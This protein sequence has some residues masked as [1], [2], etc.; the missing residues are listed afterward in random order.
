MKKVNKITKIFLIA[1]I[2]LGVSIPLNTLA[3]NDNIG[4]S[5]KIYAYQQNGKE[6]NGRYRQTK[7][8]DNPWKVKLNSSG[9][10]KGTITRFWIENSSAKNVSM[11]RNVKQGAG[12]YYTNPYASANQRDVWL[13]GENN[14]YNGK[15]Y[16]VSGIW[17]EET[18]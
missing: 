11:S 7:S 10:G 2:A 8:V 16:T 5:F 4:Y 17:D 15:S 9:E 3:S 18:W 1:I 13:T 12:A 6:K 14:N